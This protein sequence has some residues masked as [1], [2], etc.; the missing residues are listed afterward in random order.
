MAILVEEESYR[1]N[2]GQEEEVQQVDVQRAASDVLQ[3][4]TDGRE[5]REVVLVVA[6]VHEGNDKQSELRQRRRNI[7]PDE[8]DIVPLQHVHRRQDD[9]DDDQREEPLGVHQLLR[10]LP[11]AV[12]HVAEEEERQ[13][14]HDL[15]DA[16]VVEP[17]RIS[18]LATLSPREILWQVAGLVDAQRDDKQQGNGNP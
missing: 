9:Y 14:L 8:S 12:Y 15:D 7:R 3:R 18:H 4:G 2:V 10:P 11:V 5:L 16:R 6:E 13:E 17:L 1:R